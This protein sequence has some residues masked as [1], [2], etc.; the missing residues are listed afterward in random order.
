MADVQQAIDGEKEI[1]K[2]ET[3]EF[4]SKIADLNAKL[5]ITEETLEELNKVGKIKDLGEVKE[6]RASL[7]KTSKKLKKATT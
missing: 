1:S 2:K 5:L 4:E 7:K 3:R 6:V